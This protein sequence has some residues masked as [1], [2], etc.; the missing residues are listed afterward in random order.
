VEL[1]LQVI[2]ISLWMLG[3]ESR[4]SAKIIKCP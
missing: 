3:T 2:V 4:S 1:E